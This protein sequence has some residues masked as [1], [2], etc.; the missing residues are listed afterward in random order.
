M[1]A[2]CNV[3]NALADRFDHTASL[4]TQDDRE[5]ALGV[6][7]APAYVNHQSTVLTHSV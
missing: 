2:D 5:G 3:C 1:I 6:A 7:A 4:V